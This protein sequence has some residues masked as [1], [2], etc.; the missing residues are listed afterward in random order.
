MSPV[1]LSLENKLFTSPQQSINKFLQV[2]E[3]E[4]EDELEGASPSDEVNKQPTACDA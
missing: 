1:R 3:L 4:D 2:I